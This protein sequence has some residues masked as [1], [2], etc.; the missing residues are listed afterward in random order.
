MELSPYWEANNHSESQYIPV[1]KWK[2]KLHFHVHKRFPFVPV[3]SHMNPVTIFSS[4]FYDIHFNIILSSMH[5]SC[6]WRLFCISF[7]FSWCFLRWAVSRL[8]NL[9]FW[10]LPLIGC[11]LEFIQYIR[12]YPPYAEAICSIRKLRSRHAV[13]KR[14]SFNMF[15]EQIQAVLQKI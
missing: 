11:S 2:D 1:S 15:C 5:R 9:Q 8:A 4:Y 12:G 7:N 10:G 14:E 6:K 3:L 13:A